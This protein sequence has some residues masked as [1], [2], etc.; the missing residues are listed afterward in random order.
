[1]DTDAL[2]GRV[3]GTNCTLQRV[4]GQGEM[5]V[6]FLARQS[7]PERQVAVKVLLP[8]LPLSSNQYSAF[9]KR[10]QY[11][12][13]AVAALKQQNIIQIYECGE[14]E[15]MTYLVMPYVNGG[16]LRNEMDREGPFAL[17]KALTYLQQMAAA[18]DAAHEHGVI[19]G[20][21]QPANILLQQDGQLILTDFGLVK[22]IY[23]G[24][25]GGSFLVRA[26][27]PIET[28]D[29]M[30][31]EQVIGDEIGTHA[32]LYSL[33]VVLFE[34]LT[35]TV[36]FQSG[37]IAAQYQYTQPYSPR[38]LSTGL[39]IAVEQVMLKALASRPANRYT[40]AGE[41]ANAFR[42]AL[43]DAGVLPEPAKVIPSSSKPIAISPLP[44]PSSLELLGQMVSQAPARADNYNLDRISVPSSSM[45]PAPKSHKNFQQTD[46]IKKTSFPLPSMS[47]LLSQSFSQ[48]SP[49]ATET[50]PA[51]F[52][53]IIAETPAALPDQ[54]KNNRPLPPA[55]G[56][57]PG[58]TWPDEKDADVFFA[59]QPTVADATKQPESVTSLE[60][61]PIGSA[62]QKRTVSLKRKW[63]LPVA[64]LLLVL[65]LV[66]SGVFV[67]VNS[68]AATPVMVSFFAHNAVQNP[69][70]GG[71]RNGGAPNGPPANAQINTRNFQVGAQPLI[72]LNGHGGNV[73]IHT[74]S[75]SAVVVTARQRGNINGARVAY[76]QANDG[77]GHDRISITTNPGSGNVD[78]DIT[79]PSATQ[80]QVQADG[81][82][83]SVNGINGVTIDTGAG[84]L[85]IEN[86]HGPVNA[87]T[88]NGNIVGRALA[89]SIVM[90]VGNGGSI[91]LNNVNG[92]LKAI[93]HN[94]D[95]VVRE[96]TLSGTSV[97][98][99]NHGSV[100]FAGSI[101]S[102]GTY[103][104]K[105]LSGDINL[106]LPGT[107]AFQLEANTGSGS[108]NNEF[109]SATVGDAPRARITATVGNGSITVNKAV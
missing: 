70:A 103:T 63:V 64:F 104:M 96:A 10:F 62:V 65:V 94:G 39:P 17:E 60:E 8:I 9:L 88:D 51:T 108:V 4:L 74:G 77:Q 19:H 59:A 105:T 21:V 36:P 22:V 13:D 75:M 24:S 1:M 45:P 82:S 6:V 85:D 73:N 30:A 3:L 83:I 20:N 81:G 54:K 18:L 35:G 102:Q 99:T 71:N 93:S 53:R 49:A 98:E 76:K 58:W 12:I 91:R 106:T 27:M 84:N 11:E 101:D 56:S 2:I 40:H 72:V 26:R 28:L 66:L 38:L 78:Y 23:E 44:P 90:E 43:R 61:A 87:H 95:V 55:P 16:T 89:G 69:P 86:V 100:R 52:A 41:L 109:G 57:L 7:R 15:G 92:S 32:D 34:M 29:Y 80:V 31:P 5:G 25:L 79:A 68:N 48:L 37:K 46:V 67:Y 14:Y 107:T 33:G 42:Q 97:M 50:S 47:G